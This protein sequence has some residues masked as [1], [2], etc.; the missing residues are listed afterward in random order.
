MDIHLFLHYHCKTITHRHVLASFPQCNSSLL[1]FLLKLQ[2]KV[3]HDLLSYYY[4]A[5]G[6]NHGWKYQFIR[7]KKKLILWLKAA[8]RICFLV[9]VWF[10]KIQAF[11]FLRAF[12]YFTWWSKY[13][14]KD[15]TDTI[16]HFEQQTSSTLCSVLYLVHPKNQSSSICQTEQSCDQL[17]S[18][19]KKMFK[20]KRI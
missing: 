18:D 14:W 15:M 6:N 9:H 11:T 7:L 2:S 4:D 3:Q 16:K 10:S 1:Q 20:K 19:I 12:I 17:K 8:T 13:T 5:V